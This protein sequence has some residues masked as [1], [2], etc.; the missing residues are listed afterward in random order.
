MYA[1]ATMPGNPVRKSCG[2]TQARAG[3][4]GLE[5]NRHLQ[6]NKQHKVK[7][8]W[9]DELEL[10]PLTVA[11]KPRAKFCYASRMAKPKRERSE[12][13]AVTDCLWGGLSGETACERL[14]AE[15]IAGGAKRGFARMSE[16]PRGAR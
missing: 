6:I 1:P 9:D 7:H 4:T 3:Q 5:R 8:E 11:A 16:S 13:L 15:E 12:L 14:C 10:L 2:Q